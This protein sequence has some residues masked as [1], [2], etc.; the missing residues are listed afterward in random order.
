VHDSIQAPI[1]ISTAETIA[2]GGSDKGGVILA[3]QNVP[4]IVQAPHEQGTVIYLAFDPTLEPVLGWQGASAL[5]DGLLLRS[6]GDQLLSHTSN[7]PGS[8]NS[9]Q[10]GL[11]ILANRMTGF[12]QSLLPTTIPPPWRTLG[13]L[14][15][16]YILVLGP[17]RFFLV[18][19]L[20]GRYWSWR[21]ILS[22]IVI[23]SLLSY[24]LAYIEK[25]SSILSDSITIAQLSE[26]GSSAYSTTYLGVFVP[27]QG[28]YHL[29]I[30]GNG[31]AQPSPGT[32]SVQN[33]FTNSIARSHMS[34]ALQKD[35][36]DMNLQ[37]LNIWTLHTVI[38]E[39]E[40]PIHKGLTSRLTIQ[41]GT[42]IG[43]VT[44]T[45]GYALSD[46]FL[47]MPNDALSLGHLAAGE[48]KSIQL[49]LSSTPLG[50]NATLADLIALNTGSP[51]Y[52]A[53]PDSL[54]LTSWQRHLSILYALDGE[55]F[56]NYSSVCTGICNAPVSPFFP[57]L[58]ALPGINPV[59][60]GSSAPYSSAVNILATPSWQY[61]AST[62]NDPLL[63]PG[64]PATLIG[65]AANPLNPTDS[66]TINDIHPAGEHETLIQAPLSVDLG[67]SLD[68]P[69]DFIKGRLINVDGNNTQ[70]LF[71]DV[72]T[73]S[74]GSMTFEYVIPNAGNLRINGLT[75]SEPPNLNLI[76]QELATPNADSLPFRLYNWHTNTWNAI[77]LNQNTFTTNNVS[78]YIDPHGRI[79]VQL[80]NKNS[81][82]GTFVFGKPLINLQG[83]V[84]NNLSGNG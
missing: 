33:G 82:L 30:Q 75:V 19:R 15:L 63:L 49:K 37:D 78:A 35:A 68:L 76:S 38:T 57:I 28:D 67:G 69:P 56:F 61:T 10:Q 20:K 71:P 24:G 72:Y 53:M 48:T 79:L 58:P 13:I 41:N 9:P 55:G 5:W 80:N 42:L 47:L 65:W 3:S 25:G 83:A 46:V 29:S 12:L 73:I 22:S 1:T 16:C 51:T 40:H 2:Q 64:S 36:I 26:N 7:S 39:Q 77:S 70:L 66:L 43:N 32:I 8:G 62:N 34:I 17:V 18:K 81:S 74:T 6:L 59:S 45:L 31:L 4:L 44:N 84:S 60:I 14:L 23:F 52:Q 21:I 50:A 54:P 27:I 11:S